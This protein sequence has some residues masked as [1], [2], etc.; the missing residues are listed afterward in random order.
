MIERKGS[1]PVRIYDEISDLP[2]DAD[3]RPALLWSTE[4]PA[5][6]GLHDPPFAELMGGGNNDEQG[7][8]D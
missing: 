6:R 3:S 1:I 7:D 2:P 4:E 5:A 8:A